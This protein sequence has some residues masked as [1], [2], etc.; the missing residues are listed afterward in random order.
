MATQVGPHT[1]RDAS[2][3]AGTVAKLSRRMAELALAVLFSAALL[4]ASAWMVGGQD[5][6]ADNWVGVSV[7]VALFAGLLAA[8]I[9][10]VMGLVVGV[11]HGTWS[12]LRLPL[13]TFPSVLVI[14]AALEA[15]VFE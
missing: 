7:V 3:P 12:Q 9:A 8:L 6:T 10:M 14:L 15:F 5:A 4:F 1:Q 13:L 11:R 2:A